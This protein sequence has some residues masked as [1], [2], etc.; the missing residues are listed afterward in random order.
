L[1]PK[2]SPQTPRM[3]DCDGRCLGRL[4][5]LHILG[6]DHASHGPNAGRLFCYVV[7]PFYNH[8]QQA[9]RICIIPFKMFSSPRQNLALLRRGFFLRTEEWAGACLARLKPLFASGPSS[10]LPRKSSAP[11]PLPLQPTIDSPASGGGRPLFRSYELAHESGLAFGQN[12]PHPL[13]GT[14]SRPHGVLNVF[15]LHGRLHSMHRCR[16]EGYLVMRRLIEPGLKSQATALRVGEARR[17]TRR[18][19]RPTLCRLGRQPAPEPLAV[20]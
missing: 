20:Y 19:H 13:M 2:P 4:S 11:R 12:R 7:C 15:V 5:P 1:K 3:R 14:R 10:H 17:A 16:L 18:S 9:T 8:Y 6:F